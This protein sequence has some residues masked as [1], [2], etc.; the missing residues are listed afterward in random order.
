MPLH[1]HK[2]IDLQIFENESADYLVDLNDIDSLAD[3]IRL[4]SCDSGLRKKMAMSARKIVTDRYS[5]KKMVE[6][7]E[8]FY[9]RLKGDC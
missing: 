8:S 3:K 6:N 5:V 7:Y 4:L 2:G 9:F 1:F